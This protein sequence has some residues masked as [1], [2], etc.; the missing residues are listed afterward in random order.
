MNVIEAMEHLH[1]MPLPEGECP[2]KLL[3]PEGR[4]AGD[5]GWLIYVVA[6]TIL[7]GM[8]DE[9]ETKADV[10]A[11]FK[12]GDYLCRDGIVD[13]QELT[14]AAVTAWSA[15]IGDLDQQG[16]D[17]SEAKIELRESSEEDFTDEEDEDGETE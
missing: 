2:I 16:V 5:G 8:L 6:A 7:S 13:Q 14:R 12:H 9:A 10:V 1:K 15:V 4:P 11:A 3:T 17:T